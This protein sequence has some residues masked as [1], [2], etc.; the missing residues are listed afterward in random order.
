MSTASLELI[1]TGTVKPT[2]SGDQTRACSGHNAELTIYNAPDRYETE[3]ALASC[4]ARQ[5]SD[6]IDDGPSI[7]IGNSDFGPALRRGTYFVSTLPRLLRESPAAQRESMLMPF[8]DELRPSTQFST[9]TDGFAFSGE[10]ATPL[11]TGLTC[12]VRCSSEPTRHA[13]A[14]PRARPAPSS[15]PTP[16]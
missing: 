1:E 13:L 14:G 15:A 11:G 6:W 12:T 4:Q 5:A 2:S 7:E 3:S 10:I 8:L 16:P 9:A